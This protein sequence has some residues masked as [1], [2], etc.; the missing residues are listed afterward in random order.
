MWSRMKVRMTT[1][2]GRVN[3]VS[4]ATTSDHG[5]PNSSSGRALDHGAGRGGVGVS[6]STSAA[7]ES[8]WGC[9]GGGPSAGLTSSSGSWRVA[10]VQLGRL[11]NVARQRAHGPGL[12]VGPPLHAVVGNRLQ[13]CSGA[14]HDLVERRQG[15]ACLASCLLGDGQPRSGRGDCARGRATR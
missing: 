12:L 15:A 14:S 5:L 10:A 8:Y 13:V 11:A 6:A 4:P 1:A 3:R 7:E 9:C 2:L